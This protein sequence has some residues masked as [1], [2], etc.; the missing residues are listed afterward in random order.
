MPSMRPR[1]PDSARSRDLAAA[2]GLAFLV[3]GYLWRAAFCGRVFY[4]GDAQSWF[5][6]SRLHLRER[7]LAGDLPLWIP[8]L[9][10]G[11]PFLADPGNGVL[12]PLNLVLLLT[13]P[14]CVSQFLVLHLVL[15]AV[16]AFV[17]LRVLGTRTLSAAAGGACTGLSG[18]YLSMTWSG[19]YLLSISWMPLVIA[20]ALR[21]SRR[22]RPVD[23]ALFAAAAASQILSGELQGVL[24][25]AG[26]GLALVLADRETDGRKLRAVAMLGAASLLPVAIA[27]PQILPTLDLIGGSRRAGGL[28]LDE[29]VH[30]SLHPLE[31]AGAAVPWLLG[32][33]TTDAPYLG[34]FMHDEGGVVL[35]QPWMLSSYVGSLALV[36]AA[37]GIVWHDRAHRRWVIAASVAGGVALMLALGRHTPVL[38]AFVAVIP[39]AS[40]FRYPAKFFPVVACTVPMLAAAGLDAL[41]SA[42]E[43]RSER[44]PVAALVAAL[45]GSSVLALA[46]W[47]APIA[48]RMIVAM[49]PEVGI[50]AATS[51][52]RGALVREALAMAVLALATWLAWRIRPAA[53][54]PVAALAMFLQVAA[55]NLGVARTTGQ[56]IYLD[57]PILADMMVE[58]EQGGGTPRIM[59]PPDAYAPATA[60]ERTPEERGRLRTRLLEKNIGIVFG[61]GYPDAYSAASRRDRLGFWASTDDFRKQT[62]DL[63]SIG[64]ALVPSGTEVPEGIGMTPVLG[65]DEAGLRAYRNHFALP[66]CYPIDRPTF[67]AAAEQ[68]LASI[69]SPDVVRGRTAV[70][71]VSGGL[72]EPVWQG[73]EPREVPGRCSMA[74]PDG[75]RITVDC[76][77][78][79]DSWV[80]V[81]ES[82]D[83]GWRAT[84]DGRRP[85]EVAR[86]NVLVMAIR[87]PSGRHVA[88]LEYRERTLA[89]A[90]AA[91]L[92]AILGIC[93]VLVLPRILGR[94][95]S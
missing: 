45:A 12:Y 33:P 40:L 68:A 5:Y 7:I 39:G 25:T 73:P 58:S 79:R 17:L 54:A 77:L 20:L 62:L 24:L 21:L 67:A 74:R 66:G 2:V 42:L 34:F 35:R 70:I 8:H 41:E 64:W 10:L 63:Y 31:I 89:W 88:A 23:L 47:L 11:M 49:R 52:L 26:F 38:G 19:V 78:E 93:A 44:L 14:A 76:D 15:A 90:F 29:I 59:Q 94:R 48:S 95:S 86:A 85:L 32:D 65:L 37:A 36:M 61:I 83:G 6:P 60:F 22:G 57:R 4:M 69:R 91:S 13:Q 1:A 27:L 51:V 56:G 75:D 84:L 46:A 43:R 82:H 18:Y 53:A 30:W 28:G 50:E 9:D 71:E 81:N 55:G 72:Q 87:M 3:S 92:A 80:V 16:G